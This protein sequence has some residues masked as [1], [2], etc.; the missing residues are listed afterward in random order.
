MSIVV[1]ELAETLVL[2]TL[3]QRLKARHGEYEVLEHHRQ[4]EFHHDV[5]VHVLKAPPALPG[6][7]LVVSTNCNGGVKEV[8]CFH[9]RPS[10]EALW[11]RRCPDVEEFMGELPV[12][13]AEARTVHWFNP[14]ELLGPDARSELR[15]EFRKRQRGGG[16]E[17]T[18]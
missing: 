3:L 9:E 5:V 11:H 10:V 4:G 1:H 13:L 8:L 16:W 12:V 2:G 17:P 7:F 6:A 14:C 15:A 18:V